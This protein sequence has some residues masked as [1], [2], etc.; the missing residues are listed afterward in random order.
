MTSAVSKPRRRP[1]TT[2][3]T[4]DHIPDTF[5]DFRILRK[6]GQGGMGEVYLAEQISLKRK[7]AIKMLRKDVARSNALARF[8][9]ESTNI[10]KLSHA[11]VVQAYT[12]GEHEGRHYLVMEYVDGISLREYIERKGP[13]DV[14]LF[15]CILRQVANGLQRANELGIVHRDIKP[16][17]ILLT[18]KAEVKVA[19]FGLSRSLD[20]EERVD[21][22]RQGATVGTPL[23]MSPEQIESKK[24]DGRSDIYSLGVTCYHMLTGNPPFEGSN[25]YV[26]ASKHMREEPV[27]LEEARPD[28]PLAICKLVR[29][30]MAKR[31]DARHAS[32]RELLQDIA[33]IRQALGGATLPESIQVLPAPEKTT[34]LWR[35]PVWLAAFAGITAMTLAAIVTVALGVAWLS[36]SAPAVAADAPP[37]VEAKVEEAPPQDPL[38]AQKK[39]VDAILNEKSPAPTGVES[40]IDL[41]VMYLDKKQTA[42]AEALF[43]R[44]TERQAPSTYYFVGR[45][46]LAVTDAVNNDDKAARSKFTELFQSKTKDNR[47]QIL[48]DVLN[49]NPDF[50]AWVNEAD[51]HNI[52]AGVAPAGPFPPRK[53]F[54]RPTGKQPFRK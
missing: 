48:K 41:A 44:M 47:S 13:L 12:V 5:G 31:P 26:I 37:A 43:K 35:R 45:L 3:P 51:V 23:Y 32:A 39:L 42:E 53:T 24:L 15:L 9:G 2:A 8:Q 11:N 34:P 14:P 30:M 40:C 16:E 6:I 18:R 19:D 4:L 36:S 20:T 52:R 50:A 10:A 54:F 1:S 22:T 29:K 27:A 21:L 49:K 28:L 25:V 33:R 46:G 7:V 38:D 17:N